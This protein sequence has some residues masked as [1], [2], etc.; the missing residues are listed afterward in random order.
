MPRI[1]KLSPEQADATT[2]NTLDAVKKKLGMVPNMVATLALSPAALNSYLQ[3]SESL[4]GG[5]LTAQQ[6][7]IIALAVGQ[8]NGCQY[9]VSAHTM[10]A[11]SAG[12]S[13]AS[14]ASA[15]N[16]DGAGNDDA[17]IARFAQKLVAS[18]G[19]VSDEDV[20]QLRAAGIDNG[21][22]IEIVANVVLNILTNYINIVA[23]TEID[24]PVV[25]L[26]N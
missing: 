12:L 16:G 23:D 2:G 22:V 3:F 17:A 7:E 9:C 11:K 26:A 8:S 24:F 19:A 25:S 21:V 18:R 13:E 20:I 10:I 5:K 14:I 1:E 6:R 15:R 4:G